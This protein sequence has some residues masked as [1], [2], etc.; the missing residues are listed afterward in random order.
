MRHLSAR[1]RTDLTRAGVPAPSESPCPIDTTTGGNEVSTIKRPKRTLGA[2]GIALAAA[3]VA[4]GSG[5]D[6][7]AQSANPAN[8]FSAG[9]LTMSN[10]A[11]GAAIFSPSNLKPG[12]PDQTGIVDIRNS[13]SL[14]GSFSLDKDSISVTDAGAPEDLK[15]MDKEIDLT[16][17]DCGQFQ[18][19]TPPACSNGTTIYQGDLGD[20]P[21]E[22]L[23][24]YA[25]GDEH[26]YQF[27]AHLDGSADNTY[28]GDGVSARFVWNAVQ[29]P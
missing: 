10:S 22:S 13:G 24:S 23:G 8:V 14:P 5:A 25:A 20:M 17:T 9:S 12:A 21:T 16:I 3:G 7:S 19:G 18:G 1:L 27:A 4:V 26:R 28:Q 6:F 2:L 15:S 29:Q 11:S